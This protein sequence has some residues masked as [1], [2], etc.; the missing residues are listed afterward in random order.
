MQKGTKQRYAM[1][2]MLKNVGFVLDL[3]YHLPTIH[4]ILLSCTC[5]AINCSNFLHVLTRHLYKLF[6]LIT[7]GTLVLC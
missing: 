7:G 3:Y 5:V 4:I 2:M 1:K 6:D